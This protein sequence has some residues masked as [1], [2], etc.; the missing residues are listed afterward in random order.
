VDLQPE[1]IHETK[2]NE[3][4]INWHS[5]DGDVALKAIRQSKGLAAHIS[6]KNMLAFSKLLREKE[7][8]H[9]LPASTA[10]LV[11]LVEQHRKEALP[12]DRY[13]VVLTGKRS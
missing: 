4:L 7:G 12:N 2:V 6:D 1:H 3:P 8:M 11:A 10:G 9:V 13:V 5:I